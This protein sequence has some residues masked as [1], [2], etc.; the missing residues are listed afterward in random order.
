[1]PLPDPKPTSENAKASILA[2][3]MRP[4][5]YAVENYDTH[6]NI[7]RIVEV[8]N[9]GSV[10]IQGNEWERVE[11]Y[12]SDYDGEEWPGLRTVFLEG[13]SRHNKLL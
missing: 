5:F 10:R 1:M 3:F 12:F 13:F 7:H 8:D 4:G 2:R 9:S 6:G 11:S